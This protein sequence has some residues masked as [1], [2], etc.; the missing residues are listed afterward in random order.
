MFKSC[1]CCGTQWETLYKF[2]SDKSLHFI[3]IQNI[4]HPHTYPDIEHLSLTFNHKCGT[5]LMI[6][7]KKFLK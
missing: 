1:N 6:P 4:S 2:T 5:I 7:L 3:G